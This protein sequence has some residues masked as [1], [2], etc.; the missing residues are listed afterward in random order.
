MQARELLDHQ[1]NMAQTIAKFL[2]DS[3]AQS[4]GL[5]EKLMLVAGDESADSDPEKG[6]SI[7]DTYT[8]K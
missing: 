6:D 8:S 5:L 2:G 4:E 3:T 1:I 7:W